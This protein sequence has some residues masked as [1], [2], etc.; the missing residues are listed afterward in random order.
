METFIQFSS[1]HG[2]LIYSLTYMLAFIVGISIF[3]Y[4]GFRA[5]YPKRMWLWITLSGVIFFILGNKLLTNSPAQWLQFFEDFQIRDTGKHSL[6]GGIL[7]MILGAYL[8]AKWLRFPFPVL[9]KLAIAL[10]A[11]MAITRI[12]CLF[13]GCCFGEPTNLPWGLSYDA[14]SIPGHIQLSQGLIQPG[15]PFSLPIHPVQL[16]DII[17]CMSIIGLVWFTRNRWKAPGSKFLFMLT[18][19]ALF[20][21]TLEFFRDPVTDGY[22]GGSL[23]GLKAIQWAIMLAFLGMITIL[24]FRE[25]GWRNT[26]IYADP[27]RNVNF[28]EWSLFFVVI[29]FILFT[30]KWLE[31]FEVTTILIIL[32]P[33]SFLLFTRTYTLI[34][35]RPLRRIA[36]LLL[37]AMFILT[38]QTLP[39]EG[40]KIVYDEIGIGYMTGIYQKTVRKFVAKERRTSCSGEDY[41][42]KKYSDP[43]N[44]SYYFNTFGFQYSQNQI[45]SKYRR[46]GYGFGLNAVLESE[47]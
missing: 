11:G 17:C 44:H 15:D 20:R 45:Q 5:G 19:Y 22:L 21:F 12:G 41:Y 33:A 29:L 43:E 35:T 23:F 10:P 14:T 6:L 2:S 39:D 38:A 8:S 36:P 26:M 16:Y 24:Y 28:R 3:I 37:A 47:E 34:L 32:V 42:V 4:N 25:R 27:T 40:E 13:A 9:D 18:C 30:R 31:I 46:M 7:G 1:E